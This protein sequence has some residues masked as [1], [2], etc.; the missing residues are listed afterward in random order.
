M[1]DPKLV[2]GEFGAKSFG[3]KDLS[4]L[5]GPMHEDYIFPCKSQ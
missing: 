2:L 4:A 1:T 3:E 5:S